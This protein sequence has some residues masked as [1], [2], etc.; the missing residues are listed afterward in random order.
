MALLVEDGSGIT[1]AESYA[2]VAEFTAYWL[3]HGDP[4]ASN[5][6]DECKI[7]VALRIATQYLEAVCGNS[8]IGQ[9]KTKDQGLHFPVTGGVR[10]DGFTLDIRSVRG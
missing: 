9:K 10:R 3:D 8:F 4:T 1:G 5:E 7:E 6:A 2:T